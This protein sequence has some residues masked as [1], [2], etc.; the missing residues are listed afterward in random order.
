M[1]PEQKD[2]LLGLCER[3]SSKDLATLTRFAEFLLSERG[4][5][6]ESPPAGVPAPIPVPKS[7]PRPDHETVVAAI[8]R[9]SQTYFMLDKKEML[10]VTSDM[11]MQHI[12]H[13]R[14]ASDV[15]DELEAMFRQHYTQLK[16]GDTD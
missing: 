3:L 11:V 13:G 7:I 10:G 1:T 12:L 14:D 16:Q 4:A 9:L 8:K 15:I 5:A 6:A 2:T